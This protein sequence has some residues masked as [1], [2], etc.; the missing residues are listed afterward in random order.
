MSQKNGSVIDIFVVPKTFAF[1]KYTEK[2]LQTPDGAI[3]LRYPD[4][5]P[6]EIVALAEALKSKRATYLNQLSVREIVR[7]IGLAAEKW[8]DP[9][10]HYR[11]V[12]E[13]YL[14]LMTG[15]DATQ[16]TLELKQYMRLFREKELLRFVNSELANTGMAIDEFQ[17]NLSGGF[18]KFYGPDLLFQI[19]SGNVPGVQ[20]WTLIMGLLVKSAIIGKT[21]FAEP[22]MPVLFVKTLAD[23]DPR[24]ADVLAILPWSSQEVTLT[25]TAIQH[26]ETV[27]VSGSEQTVTAVRDFVPATKQ[28]IRYG[29]KIGV[30]LVG[31]IAL[32]A[33][34]YRQTAEKLVSDLG[35]YDQQACL[36]PQSVY[37][38]RGG[39]LS[40]AEFAN[41]MATALDNYQHQYRQ[42]TLQPAEKL[43]INQLRQNALSE[44]INNQTTQMFSSCEDLTWTVVYHDTP[45]FQATP[46]NRTVHVYAV[47]RLADVPNYIAPFK[48]YLQT[49][50]LAVAPQA[51]MTLARQLGEVGITRLCALGEMNHVSAAWHHDGGFNLLDLL[52]VVDIEA[53]LDQYVERFDEDVE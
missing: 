32:T 26:A 42:A 5:K 52:R 6:Q 1:E 47:D 17:P 41:V 13:K 44:M 43:A 30:A 38:E 2:V 36:A 35:V 28:L 19:F 40:P 8:T 23:V 3:Q 12:A 14:P 22:L 9:H 24:L 53:N 49:A 45:D 46:L 7:T 11:Q 10:Y 31:R 15:Y 37:I 34:Y 25:K 51:L 29:Y 21:S 39:Q 4:A 50:G 33:D 16:T 48:P 27:I 20:I 18:S